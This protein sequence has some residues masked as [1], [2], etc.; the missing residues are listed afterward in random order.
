MHSSRQQISNTTPTKTAGNRCYTPNTSRTSGYAKPP[1]PGVVSMHAQEPYN[2]AQACDG[3]TK[4]SKNLKSILPKHNLC[5]LPTL[6]EPNEELQMDFAGPISFRNHTNNY[7]IPVP[8][9]RY[10]RF[11]TT[12][13]FKDCDASSAISYLGE[14][15]K[16]H[17]IPR[18]YA[19]IRPKPSNRENSTF[20]GKTIILN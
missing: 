17:G 6:T 12:Q 19:V 16:F 15:C 1:N 3:C 5:K 8:V 9:D 10:S 4:Q 20:T 13:A 7:Y 2:K 11:L 14:Y 18:Y